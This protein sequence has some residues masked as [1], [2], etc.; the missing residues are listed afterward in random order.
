MELAG[1]LA[2]KQK[3]ILELWTERTLDSYT[4]PGFFKKSRDLFANPVGVQ[5]RNTLARLFTLLR[6]GAEPEALIQP[7]DR[8]VRIRAVQEFTASQAVVPFL[9]LK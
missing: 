6:E 9:E 7:L 5:I 8:V 2:A 1:V 4:T 3:Q